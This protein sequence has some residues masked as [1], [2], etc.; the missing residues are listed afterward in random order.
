MALFEVIIVVGLFTASVAATLIMPDVGRRAR[1]LVVGA[2]NE[3][4]NYLQTAWSIAIPNRAVVSLQRLQLGRTE[5]LRITEDAGPVRG[6]R[7]WE[8]DISDVVDRLTGQTTIQ[9]SSSGKPRR[10]RTGK[11]DMAA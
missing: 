1:R 4:A 7:S 3:L 8:L 11:P 5:T 2:T 10:S 9:F 6:S